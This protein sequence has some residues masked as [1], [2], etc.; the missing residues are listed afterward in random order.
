M[1]VYGAMKAAVQ[2]LT[3]TLAFELAADGIRVNCVAPDMIRTESAVA[4]GW[5]AADEDD[6]LER[7]NDRVIVPLGRKGRPD[8]VAD[9]VVFLASSRASYVTGVT[10]PVDGGT[11]AAAGWLRWP[12]GAGNQL[13]VCVSAALIEDGADGNALP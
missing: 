8:E 6:P 11:Q 5:F 9:C 7:V 2:S 3:K 10:L 1:A 4:A 12:D 13:P